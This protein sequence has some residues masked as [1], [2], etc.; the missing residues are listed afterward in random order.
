[1]ITRDR[2]DLIMYRNERGM[3]IIELMVVCVIIGIAFMGLAALFPLGTRNLSESR[4]RTVATDLAQEKIEELVSSAKDH[5][6]LNAGTHTDSSNPVRTTFNRFWSVAD[7]DP[8]ADM[9]RIEVW[10]T[11]PHGSDTREARL[12]THRRG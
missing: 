6:D 10:V 7:N 8:V 1:M 4:M 2:G 12:I 11:Y 9:K 5:T 3:T